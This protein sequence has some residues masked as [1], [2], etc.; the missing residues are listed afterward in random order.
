MRSNGGDMHRYCI[1]LK[2]GEVYICQRCE[3]PFNLTADDILTIRGDL[4]KVYRICTT[5]AATSD[6][7]HV[8]NVTSAL[9][10]SGRQLESVGLGDMT[11]AALD[12]IGI[13]KE[14]WA[15][16]WGEELGCTPCTGRQ[17][18]LNSVGE[19]IANFLGL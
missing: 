10:A 2:H 3:R 6:E 16:W 18:A 8:A 19:K 11:A 9:S 1:C 5:P 4:G 14:R 15:K 7:E 12:R 13:T 17:K